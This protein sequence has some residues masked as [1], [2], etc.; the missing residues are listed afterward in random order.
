MWRIRFSM[1]WMVFSE[2]ATAT[3]SPKGA[4]CSRKYLND[5][6]RIGS[7][8]KIP[9]LRKILYRV[10]PVFVGVLLLGGI[11]YTA[12]GRFR[13]ASI[14]DPLNEGV[15][16]TTKT[17]AE[18]RPSARMEAVRPVQNIAELHLFGEAPKAVSG[19]AASPSVVVPVESKLDL[20]L[21][22]IIKATRGGG[23]LAIIADARGKQDPYSV[24]SVLSKG[25]ILQE[26]NDDHV[27]LNNNNRVETLRMWEVS[28]N[29]RPYAG[30]EEIS[31]M[32]ASPSPM[33]NAMPTGTAARY[34][35]DYRKRRPS[36]R[37]SPPPPG[38]PANMP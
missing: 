28:R 22:G 30:G 13:D 18:D 26:V 36:R 35:R 37:H 34:P 11:G 27:V 33:M 8:L 38:H 1:Q 2:T 7:M 21:H 6:R 19:P 15:A 20:V 10:F 31:L 9:H 16:E 32:E 24:G 17:Q 29:E 4:L 5:Y 14:T 25:V 23:S 3:N 12:M